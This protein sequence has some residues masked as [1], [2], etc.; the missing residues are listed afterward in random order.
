M[1][2]VGVQVVEGKLFS[3]L[4]FFGIKLFCQISFSELREFLGIFCLQAAPN[5]SVL[6]VGL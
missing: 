3:A 2:L 6:K 5:I 1:Y 4:A